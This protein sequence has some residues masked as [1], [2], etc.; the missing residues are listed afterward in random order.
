MNLR[1]VAY[2]AII[3]FGGVVGGKHSVSNHQVGK[4]VLIGERVIASKH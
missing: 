3:S 2:V 4:L 1:P